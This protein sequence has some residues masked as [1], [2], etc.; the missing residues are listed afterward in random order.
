M[1]KNLQ[2]YQITLIKQVNNKFY[3]SI[4]DRID[5]NTRMIGLKGPRGAG[6]TT[7]MLQHLKYNADKKTNPFYITMDHPYFYKQSSLFETVQ[8][9]YQYGG[10]YLFIDEVHK[11]EN[12]SRELKVI[13]DGFPD[14]NVVF[15]ASSALEIYKGE[16]DLSRRVITYDFPGMSFREYLKLKHN[17]D[18]EI[19]KLSDI[20]NNHKSIADNF[21]MQFQ[22]LPL[23][24]LYLKEG[25]LPIIK[26]IS[27]D[28]YFQQ[29]IQIID[30]TINQ[31]LQFSKKLSIGAINK[32]K[33]IL[34]IIAELVPYEP[35][36][37]SIATKMGV[38]RELVYD[39]LTY[40]E[41]A[42]LLNSIRKKPKGNTVL[43]KPD[44]IYLENSNLNYA[45]NSNPEIGTIRETFFL[46]QL[47]NANIEIALPKKYDFI[48]NNKF[49]FEIGGANKQVSDKN[50]FIVA[51]G[52]E[53]GFGQ[54]IPLWLFGFLY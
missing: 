13:Y 38:R 49:T 35:N 7:I 45:L 47:R 5:W 39:F 37:T 10:R 28:L 2:D 25:Y 52:I 20:I 16:S 43:Q 22:P 6:K 33:K 12:W 44:K 27:S 30:A 15:S 23:F 31:D 3:R 19:I 34:S 50:V 42:K 36:I 46:N 4:Y 54:K 21:V 17:I 48:V 1:N 24:H 41:Q 14:L 11:Y 18:F 9:Y 26:S 8:E 40:L 51:D 32:L 53:T 29:L